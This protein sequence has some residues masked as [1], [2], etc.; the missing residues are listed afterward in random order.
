MDAAFNITNAVSNFNGVSGGDLRFFNRGALT[1]TGLNAVGDASVVNA[2]ADLNLAGQWTSSTASIFTGA[3]I[4]ESGAGAIQAA[5]LTTDAPLGLSFTGANQVGEL[6]AKTFGVLTFNNVA[7]LEVARASASNGASLTSAGT[8]TISGPVISSSG[9]RLT[10]NGGSIVEAGAGSITTSFGSLTTFSSGDTTLNSF[11]NQ[12]SSFNATSGGDVSLVN[13]GFLNVTGLSTGGSA[14]LSNAGDVNVTGAWSSSGATS[15][16]TTGGDL[17]V[18][19]FMSSGVTPGSGAM[20]LDVGGTLTVSANGPQGASVRS[21]AGQTITAQSVEVVAQGGGFADITNSGGNQRITISG[22]GTGAGLDVHT[23][24][25]GGFAQIAHNTP[26]FTQTIEVT[27]ADHINVNGASGVAMISNFGGTQTLSITGSGA[28]A[29]TLGGAG[30][31][32]PS[33]VFGGVQNVTAGTAGESGSI[34]IVGGDGNATFTGFSSGQIVGGTQSVSTS[35]A[36]RI[37][38]GNAPNQP[39]AGFSTGL[40]HN[41]SG[42]QRVSAASLEMQGGSSGVNNTAIIISSGGAGTI[43]S[44]NQVIDVAGGNL[45]LTGGSGGSN[46]TAIIVS[47]AD[48]T[49]NAGSVNLRGGE[50]GANNGAFI[51]I[52][53][54]GGG[55]GRTQTIDAGTIDIVS[56]ANSFVAIS[57]AKQI[58]T[59]VGDLRITG[60]PGDGV[61]PSGA[62]IGG[63]G[64]AVSGPTDLTLRVGGDLLLTSGGTNNSATI[65]ASPPPAGV[66]PS[67]HVIDIQAQGDVILRASAKIGARI[68]TSLLAPSAG[69]GNISITAGRSIQLHGFD[70][71]LAPAGIRTASDVALVAG[72]TILETGSGMILANRLT[73]TSSGD[74]SLTGPNAVSS[75]NGSSGGDLSLTNTGALTVTGLFAGGNATLNNAGDVTLTGFW[76]SFAASS[77]TTT[78]PGSDLNVNTFVQSNGPMTLNVDGAVRVAASG[79]QDASLTAFGGQSINARSLE[80]TSLDGRFASVGNNASGNQTITVSGGG[81]DIDSISGNGFAFITNSGTGGQL[82]SVTDGSGIRV[83][84][85]SGSGSGQINNFGAGNQTIDVSGGGGVDVRTLSGTGFSL[86]SN[87]GSGNQAISVSGGTGIDVVSGGGFATISQSALGLSQ[88]VT[89]TNA[90][91]INVNGMGGIANISANGGPQTLS[92]TG[93]GANAITV[94]SL[95]ARGVFHHRRA[96]QSRALPP[97]WRDSRARSPSLARMSPQTSVEP[98]DQHG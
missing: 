48:Q 72:T 2:L 89:A 16:T 42:E 24:T 96:A 23:L 62:R 14:T 45:E 3:A 58:I 11:A 92:I 59:T 18:T 38:G 13:N 40:F 79:V 41:G 25:S 94:G 91:H 73:T 4:V 22:G 54:P 28:N 63:A 90:D 93:S 88:A 46:N 1:V 9:I 44:G 69:T 47:F 50:G 80:V 26:G 83:R 30:S 53:G 39:P 81:I 34:T 15:V 68:G 10:A 6:D 33:Q 77:I 66:A 7:P 36:L 78:G 35:G 52:A 86:I 21:N 20:T 85:T 5:S 95:G 8:M 27:D 37:S 49:V 55:V 65:G 56:G 32:G 87:S 31:L 51:N 70:P 17:T 76:N 97:A 71:I 61:V 74:T 84:T 43:A 19:N 12:V 29:I 75:F 82:I 60:N 67:P 98:L 64:G 57:A